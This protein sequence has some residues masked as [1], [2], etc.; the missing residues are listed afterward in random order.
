[1]K[2]ELT[3]CSETSVCK[4]LTPGNY[5][6]ESIE[7]RSQPQGPLEMGPEKFFQ[8]VGNELPLKAVYYP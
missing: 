2:M 5:P 6:E 3:E 8:I 4:I 7:Y 1:M